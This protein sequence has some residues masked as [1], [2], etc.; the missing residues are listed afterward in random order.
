[1]M[2]AGWGGLGREERRYLTRGDGK[3]EWMDGG[4][5]VQ[6]RCDPVREGGCE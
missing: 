1:M 2:G 6:G 3:K 5:V 4:G